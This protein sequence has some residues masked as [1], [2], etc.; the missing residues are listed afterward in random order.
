MSK[1]EGAYRRVQREIASLEEEL[2][3]VMRQRIDGEDCERLRQRERMLLL[4]IERKR[5][6][7][8]SWR[9]SA[10]EQSISIIQ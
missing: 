3:R 8:E 4:K 7:T 2:T 9:G 10:R 1:G 6:S 5:Q